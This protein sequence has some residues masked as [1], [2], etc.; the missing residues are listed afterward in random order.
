MIVKSFLERFSK[1]SSDRALVWNDQEYTY[2]DILIAIKT[3]EDFFDHN[4]IADGSVLSWV[5]DYSPMDVGL[6][7]A[8]LKRHMIMTLHFAD[9]KSFVESDFALAR[10]NN[11]S[12]KIEK[13]N[14]DFTAHPLVKE[15][16]AQKTAGYVVLS[17]GST[18]KPKAILHRFSAILEVYRQEKKSRSILGFMPMAQ[19][20]GLYALLYCL[21]GGGSHI[22]V[23][24][25][26]PDEIARHIEKYKA[27]MLACTP[28]FIR[29]L[30]FSEVWKRY[31]LSSLEQVN[32]G[33]EPMPA[34]TIKAITA[35]LPN[36]K[37]RQKFGMSEIGVVAAETE[38]SDS[39]YLRFDKSFCDYR[40]VNNFLEVKAPTSML[41]YISGS[42]DQTYFTDDGWI[43]TGD[44][45]EQKG[46]WFR[47]L[48]RETEMIN[49][50]G[51]KVVPLEVESYLMQIPGFVE[52]IVEAEENAFMGQVVKAT[53]FTDLTNS[54]EELR[55]Q[56]RDH[57]LNLNIESYK[58]PVRMLF[59]PSDQ[60]PK[61]NKKQRKS[62]KV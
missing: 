37:F 43:R 33:T 31:D 8:G 50:G 60:I 2:A 28:S 36:I 32:Y 34:A 25:R 14:L 19:I 11:N 38:S 1:Y 35:E 13:T 41:G 44:L 22:S 6:L 42:S 27:E 47:V 24:R 21:S 48:G 16:K 52:V 29:L 54:E 5:P 12:W 46:D 30:Y 39:P 56:I 55:Q 61:T 7:F 15:L 51:R 18:G 23:Q 59:K 49:V 4:K 57:F 58:T 53:I 3:A 40:F 45:V 17:S 10:D 9:I 62:I 26:T 20:G